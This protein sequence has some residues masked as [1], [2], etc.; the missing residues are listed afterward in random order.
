MAFRFFKKTVERSGGFDL[1]YPFLYG[2]IVGMEAKNVL[3]LG[4]GF[5]TPVI[6]EALK[7]TNGALITCDQRNIK[8]TGNN[9]TLR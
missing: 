9:I 7:K 2:L 1:H 3:E 8:D 4:A 6:L 5:S